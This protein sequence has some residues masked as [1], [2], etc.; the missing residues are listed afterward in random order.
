MPA[1]RTNQSVRT[2]RPIHAHQNAVLYPLC[3]LDTVIAG[4]ETIYDPPPR[5]VIAN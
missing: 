4:I 5:A 3:A 2:P 1:P